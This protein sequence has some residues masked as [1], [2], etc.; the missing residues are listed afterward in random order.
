MTPKRVSAP[1]A[2]NP[3]T[4]DDRNW[5]RG[6]TA[7]GDGPTHRDGNQTNHDARDAGWTLPD[8]RNRG[9]TDRHEDGFEEHQQQRP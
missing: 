9:A 4:D 7:R 8:R 1:I 6:S 5:A 2:T 3:R